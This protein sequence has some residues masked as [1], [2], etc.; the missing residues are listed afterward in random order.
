MCRCGSSECRGV[1]G[2]KFQRNGQV[3]PPLLRSTRAS[4]TVPPPPPPP[5]PSSPPP[6]PPPPVG[7]VKSHLSKH[8]SCAGSITRAQE[9]VAGSQVSLLPIRPCCVATSCLVMSR[10]VPLCFA[11][12]FPLPPPSPPP[13]PVL[14][15]A[16]LVQGF[17]DPPPLVREGGGGRG[18]VTLDACLFVTNSNTVVCSCHEID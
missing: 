11:W 1:I 6:P 2:G 16:H 10:H 4:T 17:G 13:P 9:K 5:P 3:G 12:H 8:L 18:R 15:P 14:Y 7:S